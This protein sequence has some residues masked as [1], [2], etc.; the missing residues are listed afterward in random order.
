V[1]LYHTFWGTNTSSGGPSGGQLR[2]G[3]ARS[4]SI[5]STIQAMPVIG[6][7]GWTALMLGTATAVMATGRITLSLVLSGMLVW[8][9]VPVFQVLT[10]LVLVRGSRTP[11]AVALARYFAPGWY[12]WIW[13]LILSAIL[14]IVPHAGRF[15]YALLC[16]FPIPA[17]LTVRSLV[18]LRRELHGDN[19]F[20]ALR[21]VAVHQGVTYLSLAV[22]IGWTV[23]LW[24]RLAPLVS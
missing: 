10:G 12:W 17:A 18:A 16:T 6:Y 1:S 9:F 23:A 4:P 19:A 3:V 13:Y 15:L 7:I 11:R 14:L 21:H 24:A 20:T 2:I 22:Y 8:S 5:R